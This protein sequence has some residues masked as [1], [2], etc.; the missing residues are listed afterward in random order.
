MFLG[1]SLSKWQ[2]LRLLSA[3]ISE[4]V[5]YLFVIWSA[6]LQYQN[7]TNSIETSNVFGIWLGIIIGFFY[8]KERPYKTV[9]LVK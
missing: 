6:Q 2:K 7:V 1:I 9:F 8:K 4:G 3:M 5:G